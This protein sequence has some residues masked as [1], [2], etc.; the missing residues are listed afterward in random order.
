M[1]DR[2]PDVPDADD[3]LTDAGEKSGSEVTSAGRR[4]LLDAISHPRRTQIVAALLLAL[5]GFAGV[6]QVRTTVDDSTYAGYEEQELIDALSAL[7]GAAQRAQDQLDDL[8]STKSRLES[9]TTQRRTALEQAREQ[10]RNLNI[11]AGRVPVKGPGVEITITEQNDLVAPSDFLELLEELRTNGAEA[12]EVNDVR[13]VAQS[14]VAAGSNGLIADGVELESPYVVRAIGEPAGLE[15]AVTFYG[16][17][18]SHLEEDDAATVDVR[19][20]TELQIKSVRD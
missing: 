18:R 19:Q 17:P 3:A 20:V 7:T 6:I 11:L 5:V 16:G 10:T 14:Y 13:L 9:N 8:N 15:S 12:I 1:P 4:R 2:E